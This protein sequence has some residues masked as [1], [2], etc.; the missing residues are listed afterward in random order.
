VYPEAAGPASKRCRNRST[1]VAFSFAEAPP[2]PLDFK[3]SVPPATHARRQAYTDFVDTSNR[4]A[5]STAETP[6]SNNAAA[7]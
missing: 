3:A 6:A 7:S 2:D 5:T 4:A 1:C